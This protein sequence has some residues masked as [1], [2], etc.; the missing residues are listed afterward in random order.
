MTV[1]MAKRSFEELEVSEVSCESPNAKIHAV[2]ESLSPMK[3]SKTCSYFDGHITD[4]KAT[5]R[6]FGFDSEESSLSLK[7]VRKQWL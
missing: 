5:M 3:K 4:A 2:V 1:K 7:T 6:V